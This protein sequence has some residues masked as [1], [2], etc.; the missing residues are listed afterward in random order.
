MVPDRAIFIYLLSLL[1][2]L[3]CSDVSM[4]PPLCACVFAVP[5]LVHSFFFSFSIF[6]SSVL[7][8]SISICGPVSC[9][10]ACT[11]GPSVIAAVW[12]AVVFGAESSGFVPGCCCRLGGCG[13][14]V[15]A[16]MHYQPVLDRQSA[17][18]PS[19]I[20]VSQHLP[21]R[22]S[23]F[24][25]RPTCSSLLPCLAL[26]VLAPSTHTHPHFFSYLMSYYC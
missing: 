5:P 1:V 18:F 19:H 14:G 22:T 11:G 20:A 7:L 9:V 25:D 15:V 16:C 10:C 8:T 3:S 17:W 21:S 6:Q 23:P 26:V 13:R 4:I 24:N 12:L 2:C